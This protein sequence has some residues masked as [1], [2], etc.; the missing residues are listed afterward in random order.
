MRSGLK[1]VGDET[2][3]LDERQEW[4]ER[5]GW[6]HPLARQRWLL[7]AAAVAAGILAFLVSFLMKP[8]YEATSTLRLVESKLM[9][10]QRVNVLPSLGGVRALVTTSSI[11]NDAVA[12]FDLSTTEGLS[13]TEFQNRITTD[14][15][16]G[17]SL[18]RIRV[19]MSDAQRATDVANWLASRAIAINGELNQREA[20]EARDFIGKQR[21]EALA[22]LRTTEQ[23]LLEFKQRAQLDLVKKDVDATLKVR[24]ELLPLRIDVETQRA[25]LASAEADLAKTSRLIDTKRSIDRDAAMME[26]ARGTDVGGQ[27][28][29]QP[30]GQQAGAATGASA[31]GGEKSVL[32]LRLVDQELNPVYSVLEREIALTRTKL[33]GLEQ[34]VDQAVKTYGIDA[35][36]ND[37]LQ[38]MYRDQITLKSLESEYE[39][40]L[41][42]YSDLSSRYEVA[43]IQVASQSAELQLVDPAL[44]PERP[45]A[46][47]KAMNTVVGAGFGL[48]F[49]A[50]WVLLRE[51]ARRP[52]LSVPR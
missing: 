41:K 37:R 16:L 50:I 35:K 23:A 48:V 26:A 34:S 36:N 40:L 11:A 52:R 3:A 7:A 13:R 32:G 38:Q 51:S 5:E 19:R 2:P 42:I 27:P 49:A 22:K 6:L 4:E 45:I 47:R 18:V 1:P 29:G 28:T 44:I 9:E 20:L 31:G 33:R 24:E 8:V 10:E 46:P 14:Q 17:S 15:I 30:A 39:L 43:R 21:E 25:R 12:K